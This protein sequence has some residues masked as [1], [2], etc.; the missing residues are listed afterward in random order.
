[1]VLEE[2]G[3]VPYRVDRLLQQ[4]IDS[5]ALDGAVGIGLGEFVD[6]DP[7]EDAGWTLEDVLRDRLAPL[8][9]P[10]VRGLPVGHGPRN[11]AWR[12]GA[13][14]TLDADGLRQAHVG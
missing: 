11:R 4:L 7:P 10:V 1:M 14:G 5:G 8:G 13:H 9:L 6:C 2:V 12:V 3:E